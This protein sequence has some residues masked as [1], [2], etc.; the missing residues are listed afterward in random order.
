MKIQ[1]GILVQFHGQKCQLIH[2]K[3]HRKYILL[4]QIYLFNVG[5]RCFSKWKKWNV[6]LCQF[7]AV[8]LVNLFLIRINHLETMTY[9]HGLRHKKLLWNII[10]RNYE[11]LLSAEKYEN[12]RAEVR[13]ALCSLDVHVWCVST[14]ICFMIQF[15]NMDKK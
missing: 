5:N 13:A 2:N 11:I 10:E 9:I 8:T 1:F 3:C 15:S 12:F 14:I 4:K 6:L 7:R